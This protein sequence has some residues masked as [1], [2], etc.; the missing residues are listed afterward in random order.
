MNY[1]IYEN[2]EIQVWYCGFDCEIHV[3]DKHNKTSQL[4]FEEFVRIIDTIPERSREWKKDIINTWADRFGFFG[5][6]V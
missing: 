4:T 3:T 2:D 6:A 5:K 1:L